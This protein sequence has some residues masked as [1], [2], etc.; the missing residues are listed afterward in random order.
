MQMQIYKAPRYADFRELM[1]GMAT[2]YGRRPAFQLR[3]AE[4]KY[5]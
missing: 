3:V 4:G 1:N 5:T 2:A